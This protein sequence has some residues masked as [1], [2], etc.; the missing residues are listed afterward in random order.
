MLPLYKIVIFLVVS[1]G[2]VA[3]SRASL[4]K[5]RSHGFYRFFAWEVIL[6]QTLLNIEVWFSRPLAWH[7]IVSWVLLI[8]ALALAL[9]AAWLLKQLGKA[10]TRR[11]DAP[12][13][14][15]EKTTQ[16]VTIGAYRWIR[17]PLY[18]SLLVLAWGVY[19]KDPN[20]A[21]SLLVLAATVLLWATAR[22]EEAEDIRFFGTR[23][24]EYMKKTAM[25]IPYL[26]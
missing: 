15:F 6:A 5:P 21:G 24:R 22:A 16:L 13:L 1:L 20:W 4:L 17:H 9:H 11:D 25:F 2:L 19:F 7:Q 18:S 10:D 3:V 26:F 23:Y 14:G 12:L 8:A